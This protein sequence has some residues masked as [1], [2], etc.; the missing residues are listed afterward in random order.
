MGGKNR[1]QIAEKLKQRS[2]DRA[3]PNKFKGTI[4][5]LIQSLENPFLNH[6]IIKRAL[7]TQS[8][9]RSMISLKSS[10]TLTKFKPI[11][12]IEYKPIEIKEP[13]LPRTPSFTSARQKLFKILCNK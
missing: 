11:N 9:K 7:D 3:S 4:R 5:I 1:S 13:L 10:M 2:V 8:C 12:V 6:L